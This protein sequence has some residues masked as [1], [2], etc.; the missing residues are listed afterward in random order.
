MDLKMVIFFVGIMTLM[1]PEN[2][3]QN[4]MSEGEITFITSTNVYVRFESTD[5]IEN[6]DTL[7]WQE[8]KELLPCM[9][10][11][12][13]SSNSTVNKR[14][15]ACDF[16]VGDKIIFTKELN[17]LKEEIEDMPIID[18]PVERPLAEEDARIEN[19]LPTFQERIRARLSF[20]SYS[21]MSSQGDHD[22]HRIM[23]RG[24]INAQNINNGKFSFESYVNY[25]QNLFQPGTK[26]DLESKFLRLYNFALSYDVNPTM[27]ISLGRKINR[28]ISSIGAI[29]GLQVE[30]RFGGFIL[31]AIGGFKPDLFKFDFNSELL[32]YG[33]YLGYETNN[34]KLY[35][36][37][38]FGVL[39]QKNGSAIDRRYA[40]FQHSS[41]VSR[42]LTLFG[43]AEVDLYQNVNGIESSKP[44]LTNLYVSARYRFSKIVRLTV[45]YDTRKRIIYYETLRTEV[46]KLLA[47]DQAR[48][49]LRARINIRPFRFINIGAGFSRRFQS[50]RQNQSD[51]I[52]L[53]VGHSKLP[54]IG[55]RL[56][57]SANQNETN[58]LRTR[59]LSG[60][61]SRSLIRKKL[62]GD[63]YY[64]KVEYDYFGHES[65]TTQDYFGASFNIRLTKKLSLSILGELAHRTT[66]DNYR[67]NTRIIKRF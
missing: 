27:R 24:N 20:A 1:T 42:K 11:T 62:S 60:R 59:I 2:Y 26:P 13:K 34:M 39:E 47:E 14:V 23:L 58:Y 45:S 56:S 28:N 67:F 4:T 5:H 65:K 18:E 66:E 49:G 33:G 25:R 3:A 61:Y 38:T 64:R 22:R 37:T 51:N 35:T 53:Y 40:Y 15:G 46:E 63:F 21:N 10:V 31:G 16:K 55:G 17:L 9:V 50:D 57:V 8:S 48:Q 19:I 6:G 12:Q 7:Y 41:T 30:K 43:S 44:R 52:N 29:D 54:G 36:R 32:Q